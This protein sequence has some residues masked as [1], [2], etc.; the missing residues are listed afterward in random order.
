[1]LNG[2]TRRVKTPDTITKQSL[3]EYQKSVNSIIH[4]YL[5]IYVIPP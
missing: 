5:I 3:H 1:M 4:L 2:P